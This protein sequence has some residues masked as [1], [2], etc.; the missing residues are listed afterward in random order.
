MIHPSDPSYQ[1]TSSLFP[2]PFRFEL[3]SAFSFLVSMPAQS[4]YFHTSY[5]GV[6]L[7][8][9]KALFRTHIKC[10][11]Q[12]H[13]PLPFLSL[14]S[15]LFPPP[16]SLRQNLYIII[17]LHLRYVHHQSTPTPTAATTR[18]LFS[19]SYTFPLLTPL[20]HRANL[21]VPNITTWQHS[22]SMFGVCISFGE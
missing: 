21:L 7:L 12:K 14:P 2:K 4:L 5:S 8:N 17:P 20:F 9:T 19:S 11:R 22:R 10:V 6:L 13:S 15:H 1:T 16:R 18:N 3:F